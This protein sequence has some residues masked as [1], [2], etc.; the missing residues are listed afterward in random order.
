[1][2]QTSTAKIS[3]DFLKTENKGKLWS[4]LQQNGAFNGIGNNFFSKVREDFEIAAVRIEEEN[5]D[6]KKMEKN[7]I[8]LDFMIGRMKEYKERSKTQPYTAD[9]IKRTKQAEFESAL[10]QKQN[11]FNQFSAKPTPP[12]VSF[13][14]D[15]SES[16]GN[17]QDLLEKAI[18]DREN[19]SIPPPI[20]PN[21]SSD[22]SNIADIEPAKPLEPAKNTQ[23]ITVDESL[24]NTILV[25]LNTIEELIRSNTN[26]IVK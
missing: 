12:D 6:K 5:G 9:D 19:L 22:T 23:Q 21:K 24:L 13:K 25:K 3:S 17:V 7:K 26:N 4:M 16:S 1:M 20:P 14:D 2:L 18:R 8:F 10:S 15:D 11:E